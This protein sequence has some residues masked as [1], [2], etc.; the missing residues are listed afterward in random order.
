VRQNGIQSVM[1]CLSLTDTEKGKKSIYKKEKKLA[2]KPGATMNYEKRP[3]Q[4]PTMTFFNIYKDSKEDMFIAHALEFDLVCTAS[5]AEEAEKNLRLAVKTYIEYGLNN[6]WD[7]DIVFPAP[8]EFWEKIT[9]N[10]PV[11]VGEPITIERTKIFVVRSEERL[12]A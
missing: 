3:F 4:L 7:D 6:G 8:K 1:L 12:A 2:Q 10:T 5:T 11:S 9:K